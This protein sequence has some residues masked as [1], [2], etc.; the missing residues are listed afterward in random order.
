VTPI[1]FRVDLAF[2]QALR[3][4]EHRIP[5]DCRLQHSGFVLAL[6]LR[7]GLA[8]AAATHQLLVSADESEVEAIR[9]ATKDWEQLVSSHVRL[10]LIRRMPSGRLPVSHEQVGIYSG[11]AFR[12]Y[13]SSYHR[14]C[15][16]PMCLDEAARAFCTRHHA[17][18]GKGWAWYRA[19]RARTVFSATTAESIRFASLFYDRRKADL[20]EV[21]EIAL[22]GE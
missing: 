11:H 1:E 4:V 22:L 3:C 17:E 14:H 10:N 20:E 19:R 18:I 21:P 13:F 9:N 5:T 15:A 6:G 7:Y 8:G 12:E 16:L 2:V